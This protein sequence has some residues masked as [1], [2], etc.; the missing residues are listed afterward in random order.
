MSNKSLKKKLNF[1]LVV[2]IVTF[3]FCNQNF[4]STYISSYKSITLL[5]K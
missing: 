1:F 3:Y 5:F 2:N 4:E